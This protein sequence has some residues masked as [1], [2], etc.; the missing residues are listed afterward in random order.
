[1][2]GQFFLYR[3]IALKEHEA[4]KVIEE[5][6]SQGIIDGKG[7]W[8]FVCCNLRG[9]IPSLI[10]KEDLTT[11]DTRH[12]YQT[13]PCKT[14][15]DELGAQHYALVHNQSEEEKVG[16]II[17]VA[18]DESYYYYVDG[19][20]FLYPIFQLW[21]QKNIAKHE[22][23]EKAYS[24]FLAILKGVYGP[25]IEEYFRRA[26]SSDEQDYRI[27]M[28]ELATHD[29]EISQSHSRNRHIL[30]G[31]HSTIFRSSYFVQLPIPPTE[32]LMSE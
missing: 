30:G 3:G 14:F 28:C 27:A 23:R 15:A 29:L 20:D 8:N 18:I 1:M 9:M 4:E 13:F 7:S 17:K 19:R 2:S 24:K 5:I 21:D 31:R 22:G 26:A 6:R 32:L 25:K 10:D 16:I 12:G 11:N